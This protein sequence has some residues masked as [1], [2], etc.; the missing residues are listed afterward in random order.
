MREPFAQRAQ[1]MGLNVIG[2]H[3]GLYAYEDQYSQLV[4]RQLY[5]GF[6]NVNEE[7]RHETDGSP[8]PLI[9]IYTRP[10]ANVDFKY[11]G[12]VSDF[13]QFIGNDVLCQR[14]RD[15]VA[16]VG[17]PI[18][19]EHTIMSWDH[20]RMRNEIIIQSSQ[21]HTQAGDVLPVMVVNNSYN[22][23]RA[24]TLS[25]G[26]SMEYNTDRVIFAF[27]LGEMRQ[28]HIQNS[29]T[30]MRSTVTS[31]MSVFSENIADMITRNFNTPV[32]EDG[33]LAVLDVIDQYGRKRRDAISTLLEEIQPASAG[34]P[35]SWQIFLAI[36]RYSSFEQN[37]NMKRLLENAAE[38]VLVIPARMYE[39]LDQLQT[40]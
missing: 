4:Y 27:S 25:F 35:S 32:T 29:T 2:A 6:I 40:L 5:T 37:L 23:T 7:D 20:T 19:M 26:I 38:S 18:M 34:L 12:Y 11:A 33:M 15:S 24:A 30:E 17:M 21:N 13:Y 22:G 3:K 10:T 28:V 14:V 8:T 36:V 9:G 31:Y 1:D 16:S 39:V